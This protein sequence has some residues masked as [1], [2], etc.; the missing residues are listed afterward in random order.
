MIIFQNERIEKIKKFLIENQINDLIKEKFIQRDD[1][2]WGIYSI[3][4]GHRYFEDLADIIVFSL[5]SMSYIAHE[6]L[7]DM[8]EEYYH[9][10]IKTNDKCGI[11]VE[12]EYLQY[13][14]GLLFGFNPMTKHI[15]WNNGNDI[16]ETLV[17][18]FKNK[19][20]TIKEWQNKKIQIANKEIN[21]IRNLT[22]EEIKMMIRKFNIN[23]Q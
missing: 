21:D 6:H 5:P 2:G 13:Y 11:I 23:I 10:V 14:E 20:L 17:F 22:E 1:N 9:Y 19:N 4:K 8:D 16:R 12:D 18:I 15:V 7:T 3:K